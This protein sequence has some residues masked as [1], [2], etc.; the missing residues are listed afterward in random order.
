MQ[1]KWKLVDQLRGV[2]RLAVEATQNVT[3]LVETMHHTIGAG[4]EILGRPWERVTK[5]LTAPTYG[6]IRSVTSIVGASLDRMVSE[7]EPLLS[8]PGVERGIFLAA[9]NGVIGDYLVQSGSPLAMEMRF[10]HKGKPLVLTREA[11]SAE[12]PEGGRLLILLHGSSLDD[13]S[14]LRQGHNHGEA[15]AADLQLIPI[16]LRY[17]TGRHISENGRAFGELLSHLLAA[18][19][20]PVEELIFLGH[21]MGG[22]V[23]R[24]ACA[25]AEAEGFAWREKLRA[26]VTLGSPHH[27][28]PWERLG[29]WVDTLLGI[30][31]Y[32]VPFSR[33]GKLRSAGVT[34]LRYGNVLDSDWKDRDRFEKGGDPR[35]AVGL[36]QGVACFAIAGSRSREMAKVLASDGIVPVESA[37]GHHKDPAFQLA[38]A[39]DHSWVALGASHLGLL[40]SR[41]VYE[42]IREWLQEVD[43][44]KP[45]F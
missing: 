26:L 14:W 1:R 7:C 38:F 4:P 15:L 30:S 6:A 37:L 43:A 9:L 39:P 42:K 23:A 19:P 32:S 21:S 40:G 28:A 45:T 27:G 33:L 35:R 12:F 34:D 10:C 29:N 13:S 41:A 8:Q 18:W 44:K 16:H 2:T 5:L 31:R 36:P 3:D 20:R 11:L 25:I 22:L 17:N 24:S